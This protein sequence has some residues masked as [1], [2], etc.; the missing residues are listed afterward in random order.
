MYRY[1]IALLLSFL[2]FV[3]TT[4]KLRRLYNFIR[5]IGFYIGPNARQYITRSQ[6]IALPGKM[7]TEHR[8]G[9]ILISVIFGN[10]KWHIRTEVP[11]TPYVLLFGFFW[12]K[13]FPELM[14]RRYR[15]G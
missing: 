14:Q 4:R 3:C 12:N 9:F 1:V 13:Y 7:P 6:I 8:D 15:I 11:Q 5:Y 10:T 2:R